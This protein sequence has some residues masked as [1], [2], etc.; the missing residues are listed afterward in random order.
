M[1]RGAPHVHRRQPSQRGVCS[2]QEPRGSPAPLNPVGSAC[3]AQLS[4]ACLPVY[5]LTEAAMLHRHLRLGAPWAA[6]AAVLLV[7][8]RSGSRARRATDGPR[9]GRRA[10]PTFVLTSA[11]E[12]RAP[13]P[14]DEATTAAELREL[15]A[16]AA[17]R[18][19]PHATKSPG[20]PAADRPT[21]GTGSRP[22]RCS[23]AG[24][25]RA[26]PPA[27]WRCST[28]RSTMRPWRPW[29]ARRLIRGPV[30]AL[31]IPT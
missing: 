31:S 13:P 15:K 7:F 30:R 6:P 20:G 14:P 17:Q 21:G 27:T 19:R 12:L 26:W 2:P 1:L 11:Q 10:A 8:A 4:R 9:T 28:L 25:G 22:R 24:S 23:R 16:L 18:D 3:L 5:F 29:T